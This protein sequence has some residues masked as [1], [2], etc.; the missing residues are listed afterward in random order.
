MMV[1]PSVPFVHLGSEV[2]S[3]TVRFGS[4][5][6]IK[7]SDVVLFQEVELSRDHLT[8][9]V[10][11]SQRPIQESVHRKRS[12]GPTISFAWYVALK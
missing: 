5:P 3:L 1:E 7:S 8:S 12:L 11:G 6:F 9:R 10:S 4:Y 2:L